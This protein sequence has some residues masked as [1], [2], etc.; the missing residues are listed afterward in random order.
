VPGFAEVATAADMGIGDDDAAIEQTEAVRVE[1]EW[2]CVAVGA[3]S[4]NVEGIF[5]GSG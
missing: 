4:V 2:K 5:F 1:A 3:V